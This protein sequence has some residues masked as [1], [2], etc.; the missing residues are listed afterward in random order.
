MSVIYGGQA[1]KNLQIL[2]DVLHVQNVLLDM[3]YKNFP[4][5]MIQNLSTMAAWRSA[6]WHIKM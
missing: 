1:Q 3:L 5:V 2:R 6:K 4:G